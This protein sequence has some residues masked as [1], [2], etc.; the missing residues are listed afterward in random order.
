[1]HI[2]ADA[3]T[4]R[5]GCRRIQG[6]SQRVLN[7]GLQG[8]QST[9]SREDP[10]PWA[11]RVVKSDAG[12]EERGDRRKTA[13]CRAG[14]VWSGGV[15]LSEIGS[16]FGWEKMKLLGVPEEPDEPLA[17][18]SFMLLSQWEAVV[19]RVGLGVA[20]Q[21]VSLPWTCHQS[22]HFPLFRHFYSQSLD[23]CFQRGSKQRSQVFPWCRGCL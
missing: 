6:G 7:V 13:Q 8:T 23:L 21:M 11:A 9:D 15:A 16:G 17:C 3:E 5:G 22:A 18:H 2:P 12:W 14:K 20:R 19:G 1:M 4:A 10:L